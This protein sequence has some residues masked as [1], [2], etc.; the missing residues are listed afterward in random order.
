MSEAFDRVRGVR[1]LPLFPLPVVLYPGAPLPLHVFEPRYRR[2]L[3]DVQAGNKLLGMV[4]F[5]VSEAETDRPALGQIGCVAE[6]A[7]VQTLDDGRSNILTAGLI[8]YRIEEYLD[9]GEP[10]L[11][12]R[13]AFF[14]DDAEDARAL[15]KL[16]RHV[17]DLF[18]RIARAMRTINDERA[19]LPD[20]PDSD[21]ERL[22]FLIASAMELDIEV[23][24]ELLETRST[25]E[26]L[27][28]VS[29]LLDQ[30]ATS[31]EER[32]RVHAVAKSNGHASRKVDIE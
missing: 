19:A 17:S 27:T 8:R 5:D 10:Y 23:K 16:A 24:Q 22:S 20:L 28:R 11:V 7:E 15:E 29:A 26:R 9:A 21:P 25:I 14:E 12:C 18:V 31:Y 4:Y 13:P 30:A 6:V 1:E 3:A 32:A 2:M